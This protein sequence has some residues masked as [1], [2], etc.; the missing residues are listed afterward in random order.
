MREQLRIRG[1]DFTMYT[2]ILIAYDFETEGIK[3]HAPRQ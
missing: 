3:N 1:L 2:A